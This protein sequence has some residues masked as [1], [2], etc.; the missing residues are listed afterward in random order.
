MAKLAKKLVTGVTLFTILLL[1]GWSLS[2]HSDVALNVVNAA[3]AQEGDDP[4]CE[5]GD[6]R[7]CG[8]FYCSC[9]GST[10]TLCEGSSNCEGVCGEPN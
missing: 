3:Y 2:T 4:E 5:C 6:T 7:E 1:G 8:W 10:T 9:A